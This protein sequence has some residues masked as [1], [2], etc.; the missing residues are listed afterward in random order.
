MEYQRELILY[1]VGT[2]AARVVESSAR[3]SETTDA[4][5]TCEHIMTILEQYCISERNAIHEKYKFNTRTQLLER[6][7]AS[8]YSYLKTLAES[9]TNEMLRDRIVLGVKENQ[10][11]KKLFLHGNTLTLTAEVQLCRSHEIT[12]TTMSSMS[13]A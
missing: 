13:G 12:S 7:F 11:Q 3:Y 2:E 5:K 10:L 6:A 8:F 1:T 4:N 9:P